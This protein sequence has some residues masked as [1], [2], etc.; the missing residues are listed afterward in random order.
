MMTSLTPSYVGAT[1]KSVHWWETTEITLRVRDTHLVFFFTQK[2]SLKANV[3]SPKQDRSLTSCLTYLPVHREVAVA[4]AGPV[5]PAGCCARGRPIIVEWERD[6]RHSAGLS[7]VRTR[8]CKW[9]APPPTSPCGGS[10][11]KSANADPPARRGAND[12]GE[13]SSRIGRSRQTRY[14]IP[15]PPPIFHVKSGRRRPREKILDLSFRN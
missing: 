13:I 14:E 8:G 9:R 4:S 6:A 10:G 5:R 1:S 3:N 12:S 15:E 7:L 2:D 11:Q